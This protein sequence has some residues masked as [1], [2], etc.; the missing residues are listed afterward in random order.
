MLNERTSIGASSRIQT[1]TSVDMNSADDISF[2]LMG[3]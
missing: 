1:S 3:L 2:P